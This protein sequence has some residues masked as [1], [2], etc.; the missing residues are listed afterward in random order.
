MAGT[1]R[2]RENTQTHAHA[3]RRTHATQQREEYCGARLSWLIQLLCLLPFFCC[4]HGVRFPFFLYFSLAATAAGVCTRSGGVGKE[5][6]VEGCV[7]CA[8]VGLGWRRRHGERKR[9]EGRQEREGELAV[10]GLFTFGGKC[11]NSSTHGD[12]PRQRWGHRSPKTRTLPLKRDRAGEE[13]V[14]LPLQGSSSYPPLRSL[15]LL[16]LPSR[17]SLYFLHSA[18]PVNDALFISFFLP[19]GATACPSL[20]S[21]WEHK[22]DRKRLNTAAATHTHIHTHTRRDLNSTKAHTPREEKRHTTKMQHVHKAGRTTSRRGG[23]DSS[24]APSPHPPHGTWPPSPSK[25]HKEK[26]Y[27]DKEEDTRHS[28]TCACSSV[29]PDEMCN[30]RMRKAE[31]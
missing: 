19:S 1:E 25:L 4:V 14:Y 30:L 20:R 22:R 7:C 15:G 21:A 11:I 10:T 6:G 2:K 26:Q 3:H 27:G 18:L 24:D 29:H 23:G 31:R 8:C 16:R 28:R 5:G 9:L 12:A 13:R 17:N